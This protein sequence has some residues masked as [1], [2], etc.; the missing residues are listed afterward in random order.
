M[1]ITFSPVKV[2]ALVEKIK[3]QIALETLDKKH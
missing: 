2:S 1:L 3:A